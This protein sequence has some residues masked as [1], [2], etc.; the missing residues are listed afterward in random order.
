MQI[1]EVSI[2]RLQSLKRAFQ[3]A[4]QCFVHGAVL[5]RFLGRNMEFSSQHD[6]SADIM[7]CLADNALVMPDAGKV[8]RIDFRCV[9]ECAAVI[10]GFAY[11]GNAVSLFGNL[12]ISV[13]EGHASHTDF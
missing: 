13:G 4:T 11:G 8:R 9:K 7:E 6:V 12:P 10:I 2:V 5:L 3:M 1:V